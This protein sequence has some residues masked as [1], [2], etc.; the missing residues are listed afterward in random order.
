M[1]LQSAAL[2]SL[3]QNLRNYNHSENYRKNKNCNRK[4]ANQTRNENDTIIQDFV[5]A[6]VD[7]NAIPWERKF[8]LAFSMLT[9]VTAFL[10]NFLIIIALRNVS[11]LH[12]HSKV[13]FRCLACTD[14]SVGLIT[15]PVYIASLLFN[16]RSPC[17][18]VFSLLVSTH[19]IHSFRWSIYVYCNCH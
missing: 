12:P 10:G 7:A 15:Q 19:G 5:C 11:C 2:C 6:T 18:R 1:K 16:G 3:I 4:M 8:I 14:L 13:L 17:F 9:S